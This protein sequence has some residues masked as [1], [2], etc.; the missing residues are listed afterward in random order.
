M[1]YDKSA[2]RAMDLSHVRGHILRLIEGMREHIHD[3]PENAPPEDPDVILMI[4]G[5][6][7]YIEDFRIWMLHYKPSE[8]GFRFRSASRHTKR[9]KGTKYFSFV[10]DDVADA[11][12]MLYAKLRSKRKLTVGSLDMEPF[13]VLRDMIRDPQY[14]TIGGPLQ[15]V[16][17]Y[18][19]MNTLPFNV[20]WPNRE[21]GKLS[22]LGRPLLPYERN[23]F[24]TI[25]PDTF[26]TFMRKDIEAIIHSQLLQMIKS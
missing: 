26:E 8:N 15:M 22:F 10:G 5:Y 11:V 17:I 23:N 2:S 24:L 14:P 3:F 16:K 1:M 20:F 7:W 19:H 9:T 4:A 12:Q 18:R 13:E 25:D 6:S 21:S